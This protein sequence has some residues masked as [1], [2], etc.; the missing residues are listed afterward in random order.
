[1]TRAS[2]RSS[3]DR[4]CSVP[5]VQRGL[6]RAGARLLG[7]GGHVALL[8]GPRERVLGRGRRDDDLERLSD[9]DVGGFA[10]GALDDDEEASPAFADVAFKWHAVDGAGDEPTVATAIEAQRL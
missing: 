9:R 2:R 5:E 8:A 1:M 10:Q 7:R 6:D 3:Q 4:R